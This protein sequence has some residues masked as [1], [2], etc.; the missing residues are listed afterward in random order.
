MRTS[1]LI[2]LLAM[3]FCMDMA[4][5]NTVPSPTPEQAAEQLQFTEIFAFG[6]VG[7]GNQMSSGEASFRAIMASTNALALFKSVLAYGSGEAK[8]YA[9]CGIRQLAPKEFDACAAPV[10]A[11]KEEISTQHGCMMF[12]LLAGFVVGHIKNGL[13]DP[14]LAAW[15]PDGIR[16]RVLST[17]AG[18]MFGGGQIITIKPTNSA[19]WA[20]LSDIV[21]ARIKDGSNAPYLSAWLLEGPQSHPSAKGSGQKRPRQ[22]NQQV[23]PNQR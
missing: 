9:L 23:K 6:G 1:S 15:S 8:L 3:V 2:A 16:I 11:S 20:S 7:Y 22:S 14:Y 19:P 13:Y 18:K 17:E 10:I 12:H 5:A 4:A 21:A